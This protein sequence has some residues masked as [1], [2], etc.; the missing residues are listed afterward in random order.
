MKNKALEVIDHGSDLKK[1]EEVIEKGNL[2]DKE[3]SEVMNKSLN[4]LYKRSKDDELAMNILGSFVNQED[5]SFC[6]NEIDIENYYIENEYYFVEG[7]RRK[8]YEKRKLELEDL[9]LK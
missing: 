4:Y 9:R 1:W 6:D 8:N 2:K 5:L 3:F 7:N